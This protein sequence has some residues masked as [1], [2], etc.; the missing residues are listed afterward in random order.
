M[1][2]LPF[3]PQT[4][5]DAQSRYH[6]AIATTWPWVDADHHGDAPGYHREH[7]FDFPDGVRMV[8]ARVARRPEAGGGTVIMVNAVV[9]A[10]H[11]AGKA[12]GQPRTLL[13]VEDLMA[14]Y[15]DLAALPYGGVIV[16]HGIGGEGRVAWW[17][18]EDRNGED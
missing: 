14:R 17:L 3:E 11:A 5:A 2:P 4:L 1:P 15:F 9:D 12:K 10:A 8:V 18:V 13:Q 6:I 7:V 16:D